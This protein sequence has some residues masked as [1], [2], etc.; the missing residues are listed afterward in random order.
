[1]GRMVTAVVTHAGSRTGKV[2]PFPV[3]VPWWAQVEPVVAQL[4]EALGVPVIVLRLLTV[5][6]SAGARDGHVT[7]HAEAL[8]PPGKLTPCDFADDDHPLR[9]PWARPSGVRELLR[10][11]SEQVG[12][13][14]RPVQSKT[15]NL[16][17]LFRLPTAD[18]TA[19]LKAIPGF[20]AAEPAA[21]AAFAAVDPGLVP[22]V[23]ASA[24][25]RLLLADVPGPDCWEA[26]PQ[27]AADAL[28]RLVAAQARIGPRPPAIPDRR[29]GLLA[30]AVRDLLDGPVGAELSPREQRAARSLQPRWE[31]LAD[32]GLP[33]TVVHGDF[34]PGNWRR[35]VGP[36]V[37]L[38]FADA[39]WGNPVLDGLRAIG[40]LP[41][42]RRRQTTD[43]W[44]AAWTAA[45]PGSR[46]A[47]ALRIA[48][49]LAHLAYAVRYQEFLDN[50]EPSEHVYHRGDPA[51]SIRR[52]LAC[53]SALLSVNRGVY[54]RDC[55]AIPL[56]EVWRADLDDERHSWLRDNRGPWRGVRPDGTEPQHR[57]S[58]GLG[59]QVNGRR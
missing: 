34:H 15:W 25:G 39:H 50:I 47:E 33:D 32:C 42:D 20:A 43:A 49:P 48:E 23:V 58:A 17:G 38:D 7:Y 53:A 46:P 45:A 56:S 21:I 1:M 29:P 28:G 16:S 11:A 9:L 2:G 22:T 26:S 36:P 13:T 44:I 37:V 18:G 10:W 59:L 41:A 30:A 40:F 5:E 3:K 8:E 12:L 54:R 31:M 6:G 51:A 55:Q 35:G 19:W 27:V 24:P 52:A 57:F 4:E 14:G